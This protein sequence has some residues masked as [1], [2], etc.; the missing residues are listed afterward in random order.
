[1]RIS[2]YQ[3]GAKRCESNVRLVPAMTPRLVTIGV[4]D[5]IYLLVKAE[6][7]GYRGAGIVEGAA[8]L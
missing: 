3:E 2:F 7:L 4:R 5:P 8:D 1:M 6:R